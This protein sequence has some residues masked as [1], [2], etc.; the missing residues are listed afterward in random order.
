ML[1]QHEP[2]SREHSAANPQGDHRRR[3]KG[4]RQRKPRR[5]CE[6]SQDTE[7]RRLGMLF[8]GRSAFLVAVGGAGVRRERK[9]PCQQ[10]AVGK[11]DYQQ[12]QQA[13]DFLNHLHG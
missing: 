2:N 8:A 13:L 6:C 4:R 12:R 1:E 10:V 5:K 11:E 9:V 3:S 7:R